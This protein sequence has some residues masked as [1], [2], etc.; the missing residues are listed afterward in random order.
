M[1]QRL[2]E[3]YKPF[4]VSPVRPK[5]R[6]TCRM[7][8]EAKIVLK[9]CMELRKIILNL[10]PENDKEKFAF[11]KNINEISNKTLCNKANPTHDC[12]TRNSQ[13]CAVSK[14]QFLDEEMD[15]S[16]NVKDVRLAILELDGLDSTVNSPVIVSEQFI[17][18]SPDFQHDIYFTLHCQKSIFDFLK[19]VSADITVMHEFT[20]GCSSQYKSRNCIGDVS[21][22]A[23][24]ELGYSKLIRNNYETSHSKGRG[25]PETSSG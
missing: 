8:V 11:F 19:S 18:I 20:D 23:E 22:V 7:H 10:H 9:K 1:C 12:L 14:L 6:N 21:F 25:I 13:N 4:F 5:D 15:Q 2:F 3:C 24:S 16:P 17:V